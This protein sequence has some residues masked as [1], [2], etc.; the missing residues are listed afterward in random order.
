[1]SRFVTI[2]EDEYTKAICIITD[3]NGII[4][5]YGDT[6]KF[7]DLSSRLVATYIRIEEFTDDKIDPEGLFY[8]ALPRYAYEH[9]LLTVIHNDTKTKTKMGQFIQYFDTKLTYDWTHYRNP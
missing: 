4:M 2:T 3:D 6:Y 9:G 7:H 5:K 1:M 8:K